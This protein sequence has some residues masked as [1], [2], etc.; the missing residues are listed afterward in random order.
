MKAQ[1]GGT[2]PTIFA[3]YTN[4]ILFAGLCWFY[5]MWFD[6]DKQYIVSWILLFWITFSSIIVVYN[7]Y[8]TEKI[9]FKFSDNITLF[10]MRSSTPIFPLTL[11]GLIVSGMIALFVSL[12]LIV[13]PMKKKVDNSDKDKKFKLPFNNQYLFFI[14]KILS[15]ILSGILILSCFALFFG[16]PEISE[17]SH[18]FSNINL[19]KNVLCYIVPSLLIVVFLISLMVLSVNFFTSTYNL[20]VI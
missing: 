13:I 6:L 20:K 11:F 3:M 5:V 7:L 18:G 12:L 2:N 10:N 19:L 17:T 1:K 9:Q 4:I 15:V 14:C 16:V 8:T